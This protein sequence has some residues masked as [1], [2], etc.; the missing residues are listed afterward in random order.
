LA[1]PSMIH[2]DTPPLGRDAVINLIIFFTYAVIL[3]TLVLQGLTLPFLIRW[4]KVTDTGETDDEEREARLKANLAATARLMELEENDRYPKELLQR[5]RVEYEDR[6]RQLEACDQSENDGSHRL[7]SSEYEH[8][9][10]EALD[11]ER[12]T[13][14]QLRN[15]RVINDQALRRIQRD[16]DLAEARLRGAE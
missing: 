16:L 7:F 6:I 5:L 14:I 12:R 8:L 3:V 4:L 9:Q 2:N 1:L 13:I 11:I 15:E 10:Q